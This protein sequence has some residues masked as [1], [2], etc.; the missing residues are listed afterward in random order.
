MVALRRV[1][2]RVKIIS[3]D[4]IFMSF[5]LRA[6]IFCDLEGVGCGVLKDNR[7]E[8]LMLVQFYFY[9]GKFVLCVLE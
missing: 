1:C 9:F 8:V 2:W 6:I 5:V 3:L 7:G 4:G